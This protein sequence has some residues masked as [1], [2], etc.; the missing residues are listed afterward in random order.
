[1]QKNFDSKLPLSTLVYVGIAGMSGILFG[2][3]T[4]VMSGVLLLLNKEF[5]INAT[6]NGIFV[7]A[8]LIGAAIGSL[9][10][11]KIVTSK[12]HRKLLNFLGVVFVLLI[13]GYVYANSFYIICFYQLLIGLSIGIT[14]FVAPSYISEISPEN[15][16]GGMISI[17][18]LLIVIGILLAYSVDYYIVHTSHNWREMVFW[19]IIP[20]ILFLIGTF[21]L[22]DSPR[23]LI[24]QNRH[25]EALQAL[26]RIRNYNAMIEFDKMKSIDRCASNSNASWSNLFIKP[27]IN[28]TIIAIIIKLFTQLTG[29]NAIIYYLPQVFIKLGFVFDNSLLIS[30]IVGTAN[31]IA[32]ICAILLLD[33]IGRRPLMIYG[34]SIMTISLFLFLY[35]IYYPKQLLSVQISC[36]S[37]IIFTFAF[38]FSF[39]VFGWVIIS[40]IFPYKVRHI[41]ASLG[42]SINWLGN[43]CVSFCFPIALQRFGL[44]TSMSFFA[45]MSLS[46]L[47]YCIV[48]VP[49]T[50]GLSL[51]EIE[52]NLAQG[53]D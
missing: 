37:I 41:G 21:A 4:G 11:G 28:A 49:E 42:A 34:S 18:Q 46:S 26:S 20:A 51:E 35:S 19:G 14:S 44:F 25:D 22:P 7:G 36:I 27:T 15:F 9:F 50:K 5:M 39:G 13:V 30:V 17:F 45:L 16:R 31:L 52:N 1:M 38:A 12:G 10:F 47:V 2:Y 6:E 53:L 8:L 3:Y 23:W 32:T 29:I 43:I 24:N 48:Y 33:K 40:E